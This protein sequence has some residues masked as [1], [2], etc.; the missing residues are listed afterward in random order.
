[1]RLATRYLI[2]LLFAALAS[3]AAG[4]TF[5]A[6]S[7]KLADPEIQ[8]SIV[9][10][11][12]GSNDPGHFRIPR[13]SMYDLLTRAFGVRPDQIVAPAWIRDYPPEPRYT[14]IATMPPDT[15]R[16]QF[17]QMLQNLL[18]ER[19]HLVFHRETRKFPGYDLVV[20]K[21]GPK[22]KE[23]TPAQEANSD[24]RGMNSPRG[25]DGFPNLP[26]SRI[27]GHGNGSGGQ[28]IKYQEQTMA[29]F[30]SNVGFLIGDSQ[31]RSFLEGN[32][33]PRVADKTGLTG[34]YT[35]ILEYRGA[36]EPDADLPNIFVAAQKQLGLR[37]DKTADAP[38]DVIV[39]ES[40][41][42]APTEN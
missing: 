29:Q 31:G 8:Q 18:I 23:V 14:L 32:P 41:D 5:D 28:K 22:F 21:D 16:E 9:T 2:A 26:G 35:F 42:K 27:M 3:S 15:T 30:A 6:A 4:P 40:V 10:G 36:A 13:T 37:L 19:F 25:A 20:D 24:R 38:V 12:P 1:M 7:V 34:T 33:Q 17:E 11:G 39:V